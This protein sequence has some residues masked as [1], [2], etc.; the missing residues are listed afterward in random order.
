MLGVTDLADAFMQITIVAHTVA[1]KQWQVERNIR[2][3]IKKKFA[4]K[5]IEIPYPQ[6][7]IYAATTTRG[8]V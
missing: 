3:T 6:R 1:M 4:E 2:R 5:G 8:S 7:D